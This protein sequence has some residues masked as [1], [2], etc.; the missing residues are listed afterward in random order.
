[1]E[2]LHFGIKDGAPCCKMRMGDAV[3]QNGSSGSMS[4][5]F[6]LVPSTYRREKTS[7]QHDPGCMECVICGILESGG[8][9]RG[10]A[11]LHQEFRRITL[12]LR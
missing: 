12:T 8:R 11:D 4:Q 10:R 7:R 1:M 5:R 6:P 2:A 3:Q 9:W